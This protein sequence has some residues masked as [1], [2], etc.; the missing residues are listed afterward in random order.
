MSANSGTQMANSFNNVARSAANNVSN[1][2]QMPKPASN[3][4]NNAGRST[5]LANA[6][7]NNTSS[8]KAPVAAEATK[9]G[10]RNMM[11]IVIQV[12]V[13]IVVTYLIYLIALHIMNVDKLVIDEKHDLAK[14]KQVKVID[15]FIDASSKNVRYNTTMPIANNYLPIR[16][17]VNIKGGAQFT[18]SFWVFRDA[19]ADAANKILFLKGDDKR[20][21]FSIKNN[22]DKKVPLVEKYNEHMVYCPM[23]KF[24][25]DPSTYEIKFNT[26][27]KYDETMVVERLTSSDSAYRNNLMATLD[28]TW[29]L[30]TISFEDNIPIN[31]F[32]N[33]I[34]V[35][36][37]V[38]DV[39]YKV[40]RF[41]S[42][43]KQNQGDL[44][45]FPNGNTPISNVKISNFT[46]Y[47]YVL[48]EE[49][50]RANA[51]AGANTAPS[52]AYASPVSSKPPVLSDYNKLDI[53]NL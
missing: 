8:A 47:N 7:G 27:A 17:S 11:S 48:S 4:I 10:G 26:L 12:L 22:F 34:M 39:L 37:Y 30:I 31:D 13:G 49:E 32:E 16:P 28:N 9:F 24:G 3:V 36:F 23:V 41:P 46:Y 40:S 20:Y 25:S 52:S 42:A 18:Y 5:P 2:A 45:L 14:K 15:G 21:S 51:L 50:I 29:H 1:N 53:Y 35:K 43:L 38:N 6:K 33:G 44:F 19:N